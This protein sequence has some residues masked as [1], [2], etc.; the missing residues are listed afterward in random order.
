M[1][2]LFGDEDLEK[3]SVAHA[4]GF[5]PEYQIRVEAPDGG[6]VEAPQHG[7]QVVQRRVGAH[8]ATS[9]AASRTTYSAP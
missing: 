5:G 9:C 8:E 2:D 3:L 1:G 6:Q 4:F 7:V